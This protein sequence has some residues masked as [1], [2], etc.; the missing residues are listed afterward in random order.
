MK[1]IVA[2]DGL[3]KLCGLRPEEPVTVVETGE[4]VEASQVKTLPTDPDV[5]VA[6]RDGRRYVVLGETP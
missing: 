6:T 5:L 2:R 3:G 1:F 4:T